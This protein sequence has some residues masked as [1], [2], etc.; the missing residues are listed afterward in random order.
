MSNGETLTGQCPSSNAGPVIHT[1]PAPMLLDAAEAAR[2]LGV[3][4]STFWTYHNAGRVPLPIRLSARVVK[5]RKTELEAW[6]R[7]G[8][9]RRAFW[10]YNPATT[11]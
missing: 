1:K 7:A 10:N 2:L 6:V 3:S 11:A 5:W 8:C 4:R 9:P